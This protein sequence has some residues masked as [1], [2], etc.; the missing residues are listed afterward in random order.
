MNDWDIG[1]DAEEPPKYEPRVRFECAR[2]M[3]SIFEG[4][5]YYDLGGDPIC[6]VCIDEARRTA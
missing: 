6:E 5:T 1:Y 2:C 3:E 4:D